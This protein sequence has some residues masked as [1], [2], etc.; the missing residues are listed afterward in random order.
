[1]TAFDLARTEEIERLLA[2]PV[3]GR[4][5]A[6]VAA[7]YAAAPDASMAAGDPQVAHGPDGFPYFM[8]HL[9]PIGEAF[10][11]YSVNHVLHDCTER[12]TGCV[13][14]GRD[15]DTPWVF[16]YGHLWSLR[17]FGA[18]DTTPPGARRRP[19]PEGAPLLVASPGDEL[20]PPWARAVLRS[21][22]AFM[23]VNDP[24]LVLVVDGNGY[25]DAPADWLSFSIF[26]DQFA[27]PA[28]YTA[29]MD[30]LHWFLPPRFAVLGVQR[31][32]FDYG[33]L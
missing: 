3:E 31:G 10:T 28:R 2:V 19:P 8:L 13:L 5:Q 6:W 32:V 12:G 16:S 29:T 30:R 1:M 26:P 23:G 17:A 24:G 25:G 20:L 18:F 7:L 27:D 11:A 22:L 4:D 9:P 14:R 33:P 15:Q 21:W